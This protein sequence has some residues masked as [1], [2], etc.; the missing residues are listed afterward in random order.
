MSNEPM[1]VMGCQLKSD[2]MC[3]LMKSAMGELAG[4]IV[5]GLP[6]FQ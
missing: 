6:K 1:E 3:T 4:E 5:C 2:K